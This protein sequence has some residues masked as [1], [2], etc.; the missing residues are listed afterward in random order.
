MKMDPV[1][2]KIR[3]VNVALFLSY[4]LFLAI[5]FISTALR[6]FSISTILLYILIFYPSIIP[7]VVLFLEQR[8]VEE[9]KQKLSE[10]TNGN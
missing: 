6:L 9:K 4:F 2:K 5:F 1:T 10:H 7:F 3:L 8:P